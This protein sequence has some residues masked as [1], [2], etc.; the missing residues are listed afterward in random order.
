VS[1]QACDGSSTGPVRVGWTRHVRASCIR[2]VAHPSRAD[3]VAA[4]ARI[5]ARPGQEPY[6]CQLCDHWHW[7]SRTGF[8]PFPPEV[9]S[10]WRPNVGPMRL[11]QAKRR[12]RNRQE[13][14]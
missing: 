7:G 8:P 11:L 5:G 6:Q 3:A 2:K 10:E 9:I 1:E 14:K 12:P 13:A 4:M